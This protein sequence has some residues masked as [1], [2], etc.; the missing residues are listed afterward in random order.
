MQKV[1]IE[2]GKAALS[3]MVA[4]IAYYSFGHALY[5]GPSNPGEMI[6]GLTIGFFIVAPIKWLI[7]YVAWRFALAR[8]GNKKNITWNA[9]VVAGL[10]AGAVALLVPPYAI[11][12]PIQLSNF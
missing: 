5:V 12:A 1:L 8:V 11:N 6:E 2:I 4:E 9:A 3:F 7:F 10:V